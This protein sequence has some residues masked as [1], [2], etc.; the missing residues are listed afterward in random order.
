MIKEITLI[1][2]VAIAMH[3]YFRVN[4]EKTVA[5]AILYQGLLLLVDYI[6]FSINNNLFLSEEVTHQQYALQASLIIVFGKIILFLCIILIKKQFGNKTTEV[7]AD[8]EWIRFLVF[9]IFTIITIAAMIMKFKYIE[10]QTQLN[11]L[12]TIAMG[13]VV[14][15]V[16]FYYLLNDIVKREMELQGKRLFELQVK[17]QVEMYRSVSERY[18]QQKN[19]SHEF[20]NQILCIEALLQN[21]DYDELNRYVKVISGALNHEHNAIN[22]NHVIINAILNTKYQE[23]INKHIVFVIKV[24]NLSEIRMEDGDIVILLSNLLNNAIEACEQCDTKRVIKLKFMKEEDSI[25]ISVKN[26]FQHTLVYE[27]NEIETSKTKKP[28]EHGV[29]IKNIIRVV[30]KY[31]GSYVI[32]NENNEFYFSMMI[33]A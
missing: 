30:D 11:V 31:K 22:T 23:A 17:N 1:V 21:Q 24:N 19:N 28:E 7:L 6:V 8:T 12:Y 18:E 5:F 14:M 26:T 32:Q 33:P 10:E 13:M 3:F 9:P 20:K 16:F 2:I 27:N 25:I 15:N 29:G 4:I